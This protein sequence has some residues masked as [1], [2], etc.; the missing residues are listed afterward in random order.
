M[1]EYKR[2]QLS[3]GSAQPRQQTKCPRS[4]SSLHFSVLL[5]HT[6]KCRP[7]DEEVHKLATRVS[8]FKCKA[9]RFH[10]LIFQVRPEIESKIGKTFQVL[11]AI[12]ARDQLTSILLCNIKV[13]VDGKDNFIISRM[14][15][16]ICTVSKPTRGTKIL[17]KMALK[18]EI[19]NMLS[20]QIVLSDVD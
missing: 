8:K 14:D 4:P 15:L 12:S 9:I 3:F 19:E 6:N 7:A 13:Q 2:A 17:S 10:F 11:K 16:F 20:K 1:W 18:F 5:T